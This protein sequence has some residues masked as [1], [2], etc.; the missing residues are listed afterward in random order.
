MSIQEWSEGHLSFP[1]DDRRQS[2]RF[3]IKSPLRWV[4]LNRK[5]G[6][7][8]GSGETLDFSSSGFAFR[9]DVALPLGC[10]LQLD[11]EWP[12]EL[13]GRVPM[14]LVVIGKVVRVD[15][16]VA[17]VT[18]EKREFRTAGRKASQPGI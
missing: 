10:R 15:G 14:K 5:A 12:A 3:P 11:V 4:V 7:L 13:D 9:S 1:E 6:P 2:I 18:I 16:R 17:C 8:S